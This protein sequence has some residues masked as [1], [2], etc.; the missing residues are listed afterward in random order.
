M[1]VWTQNATINMTVLAFLVPVL[2][3]ALFDIVSHCMCLQD[4]SKLQ[5]NCQLKHTAEEN[6]PI[7]VFVESPDICYAGSYNR[8]TVLENHSQKLYGEISRFLKIY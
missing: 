6:R 4:V 8:M 5:D 2:H 3:R 1:V 7:A